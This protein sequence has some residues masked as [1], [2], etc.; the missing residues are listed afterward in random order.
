[1]RHHLGPAPLLFTSTLREM[2]RPHLLLVTGRDLELALGK[3]AQPHEARSLHWLEPITDIL[4]LV[5]FDKPGLHGDAKQA[6]I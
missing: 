3:T 2:R 6:E 4:P 5:P 1:M